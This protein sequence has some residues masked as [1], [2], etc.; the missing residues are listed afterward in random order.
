MSRLS[1][2]VAGPM[3]GYK[4][5]NYQMF[6]EVSW[7]AK[8]HQWKWNGVPID[9]AS[10]TSVDRALKL[11]IS[12]DNIGEYTIGLIHL[13]TASVTVCDGIILLP[14]WYNSKGTIHELSIM[15]RKGGYLS[16]YDPK[17]KSIFEIKPR[18]CWERLWSLSDI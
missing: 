2:Y 1:F 8:A 4:D 14:N 7:V 17:T 9:V 15:I 16:E 10:P 11:K 5:F 3:T 18:N 13:N 12:E 6:D